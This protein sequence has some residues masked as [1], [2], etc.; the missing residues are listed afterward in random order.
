MTVGNFIGTNYFVITA[1]SSVAQSRDT[2]ILSVKILHIQFL[3][4]F[5]AF[6]RET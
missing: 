5:L 6:W 2:I 1:D 4:H 3:F